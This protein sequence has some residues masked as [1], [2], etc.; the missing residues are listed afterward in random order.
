MEKDVIRQPES[1]DPFLQRAIEYWLDS[2]N[3]LGYQPLFCEWLITQGDILKYSIKNTN[4]EQGKDVVAVAQSGEPNAYQLK[5][6]SIN[7]KRWRSEVKPEIDAL[8]GCA[9]QH[10]DIDKNKPHVSY[11]VT[12]GEIEDSV[13]VEIVA[14][15]EKEW[16]DTPLHTWTAW[17]FIR[18]VSGNGG[19]HSSKRCSDV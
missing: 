7:L 8:I 4:F 6:G 14:L 16:K 5:G 3:E 12:N 19:R 9:I 17:R 11:L 13:R 2:T 15:N 18:W 10:P 1:K